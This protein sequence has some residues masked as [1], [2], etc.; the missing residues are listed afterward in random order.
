MAIRINM[1]MSMLHVRLAAT[2]KQTVLTNYLSASSLVGWACTHASRVKRW[3]YYHLSIN[4]TLP[5]C[6][7]FTQS[8]PLYLVRCFSLAGFDQ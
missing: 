1:Q 7:G 4:R 2:A 8:S 6:S 5:N 3:F